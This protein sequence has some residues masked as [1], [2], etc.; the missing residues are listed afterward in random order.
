MYCAYCYGILYL[1]IVTFPTVWTDYHEE[2]VSI[3][4]LKYVSLFV[5]MGIASQLRTRL[6]DRDHKRLQ[7]EG[8]GGQGRPEFRLPVLILG[9]LVVPVGLF[10]TDGV[11]GPIYTGSCR[12]YLS[13]FDIIPIM[14]VR[15]YL[16][17]TRDCKISPTKT[18]KARCS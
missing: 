11:R 13:I 9:A 18:L 12:E 7:C 2:T 14:V 17:M 15:L 6:A 16:C 3:G 5:G 1:L 8:N 10:G 4:S